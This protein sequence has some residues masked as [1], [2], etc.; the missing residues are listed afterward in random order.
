MKISIFAEIYL[1]YVSDRLYKKSIIVTAHIIRGVHEK[2][3]YEC[4]CQL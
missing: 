4:K 3:R 1:Q 2:Q